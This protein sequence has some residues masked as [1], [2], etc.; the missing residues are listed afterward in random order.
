VCTA[1]YAGG[2]RGEP[3]PDLSTISPGRLGAWCRTVLVALRRAGLVE[4]PNHVAAKARR[5][6]GQIA[7]RLKVEPPGRDAATDTA[8]AIRELVAVIAW[9]RERDGSPE[10]GVFEPGSRA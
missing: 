4:C 6:A 8:G 1:A 7:E 10:V 9:C 2:G 5:L 3:I